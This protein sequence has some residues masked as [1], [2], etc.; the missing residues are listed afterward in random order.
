MAART[1]QFDPDG[2]FPR[3]FSRDCLEVD[4]EVAKGKLLTVLVNHF[5][6]KIAGGEEKR[7][8]QA[9]RVK[10][11][12]KARF[13]AKLGG[14]FVVCADL[15]AGPSEPEIQSLLKGL[16]NVQER[17]ADEDDRWTH[18][19]KKTKSAEQLDYL[20]LSPALASANPDAVPEVERRGL[21][22][23]IDIY[24]GE[25]FGK[26]SGSEGASDHCPIFMDLV[27]P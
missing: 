11:I 16:E 2:G 21:G 27:V 25:R 13:G 7:A 3:I 19:Y 20:L 22:T 5:K 24:D 12:L 14:N 26:L 23:D 15:N 8:A 4:V 10:E 9:R 1:H 17:I 18:Y 6:S